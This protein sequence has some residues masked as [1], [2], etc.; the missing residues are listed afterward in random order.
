[1]DLPPHPVNSHHQDYDWVSGVDPTWIVEVRRL[2]LI[3]A[4]P[5]LGCD[6]G[7]AKEPRAI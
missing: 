6:I 2:I 3:I 1:L 7:G 5:H 4:S